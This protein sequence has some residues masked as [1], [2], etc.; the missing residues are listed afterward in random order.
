MHVIINERQIRKGVYGRSLRE[1]R[2]GRNDVIIISYIKDT[3]PYVIVKTFKIEYTC[4]S[5]IYRINS[6]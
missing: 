2:E 6:S 5:K 4:I 1:E 3:F